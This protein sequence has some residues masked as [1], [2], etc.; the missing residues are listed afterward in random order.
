MAITSVLSTFVVFEMGVTHNKSLIER[1]FSRALHRYHTMAVVQQRIAHRLCELIDGNR[2]KS[3]VEIG[4]GSGFLTERLVAKFPEMHWIA[5]D[6]TSASEQFMPPSV[7]FICCD[8]ETMELPTDVD[9]IATASTVQ[10]FDNL[11]DFISRAAAALSADGVLAI[12]TFGRENFSEITSEMEYY[13][14]SEIEQLLSRENLTVIHSQ[15]WIEQMR[16]ENPLE[17]LRHIKSTG[18][19]ALTSTRWT[20]KELQQ[21]INNYPTPATLTFHPILIVAKVADK[22]FKQPLS[23]E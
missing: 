4:A 17:V 9:I 14:K 7:E 19:N 20:S 15:E 13:S 5:N 6:I 2:G 8:G 23:S 16:F 11:P 10:W 1:R 3:G 18:V 22:E 12:A 21:F